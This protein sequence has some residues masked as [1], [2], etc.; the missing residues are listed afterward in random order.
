M[1]TDDF[2]G[3]CPDCGS[4]GESGCCPRFCDRCRSR[5]DDGDNP[6]AVRADFGRGPVTY[7]VPDEDE[8]EGE[9]A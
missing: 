7:Y 1:T 3:C 2:D 9:A 4:C 8:D 6:K 5:H